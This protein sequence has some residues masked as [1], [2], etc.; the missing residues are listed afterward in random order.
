MNF[1]P[2]TEKQAR[3]IW[4]AVTGLAIATIVAL[5]VAL[6][7]GL[8]RVLN[9][10][11]PVIWPLAVAGVVA[12]LLDPVVEFLVRKRVPRLRAIVVVFVLALVIVIAFASSVVPQIV[13][14]VRDLAV[15]TSTFKTELPDRAG[16][17]ATNPPSWL[18]KQA[19]PLLRAFSES[20]SQ[21]TNAPAVTTTIVIETNAPAVGLPRPSQESAAPSMLKSVAD[22]ASRL[23]PK[24]GGWLAQVMVFVGSVFGIIAGL[25]LVPIYAFY[26]LLEKQGISSKWRDYLPVQDSRF[27]DELAFVINSIN[28]YLVA[29]FR[30]Q[31]LVAMCDG[32]LYTIGFV[33]I[34]LPYAVL[35]GAMA[36][37]LTIIPFLGAITTCVSALV[38]ALV[39]FG[40]WQH[41]ALVLGVF[42]VVQSLEGFVIQPKIMGDRVGLHPVTIIVALMVGTTL[43]GGILGGIL[44][45]PLA[46]VLRVL[47]ARYVWQ[48]KESS[49]PVLKH[50]A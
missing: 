46:A 34:G 26:F 30:G 6:V 23:L 10:F 32:V 42:A 44:A 28:E 24:F 50:V 45:I 49:T 16:Q 18:P 48:K 22:Y 36:T 40:D 14:E 43:L 12:C 4:I 15:K 21:A 19:V 1:T 27:K 7:W 38:I 37:C 13:V 9:V 29:F 25:A 5:I 47:M 31:V 33:I 2:P 11:A 3:V 8:G 20:A 39:A 41:P 17:M 35:I